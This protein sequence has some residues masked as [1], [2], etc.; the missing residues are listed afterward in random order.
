MKNQPAP[1]PEARKETKATPSPA[2]DTDEE[3]AKN[4]LSSEMF[5]PLLYNCSMLP[6]N[7]EQLLDLIREKDNR[8]F[9]VRSFVPFH[10]STSLRTP[11]S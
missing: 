2:L 11:L 4:I 10:F 5:V 7:C 3:Y 8:L 9:N 6:R 1:K